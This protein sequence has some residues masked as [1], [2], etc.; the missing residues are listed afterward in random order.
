MWQLPPQQQACLN[1]I[2][3]KVKYWK[4]ETTS[5]TVNNT[6]TTNTNTSSLEEEHCGQ[7]L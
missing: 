4:Q 6:A 3:Q 1:K 5:E 7:G 2:N